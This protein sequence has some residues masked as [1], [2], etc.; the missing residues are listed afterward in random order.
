MEK[1]LIIVESPGKINKIQKYLGSD[2]IVKASCG[3]IRDLPKNDINI[4]IT[5]NFKP[6][7]KINQNK[8]KIIKELKNLSSSCKETIIATDNDREGEFIAQSLKE[9]L[10]ISNPK[11]ILFN[12]ITKDAIIQS[13]N[14]PTI[15]DINKVKSQETR[16]FLDRIIGYKLSPLLWNNVSSSAKSAGRVQSIALNIVIN[17]EKE[18]QEFLI[19]NNLSNFKIK[20]ILS[21]IDNINEKNI[22]S[23]LDYI[24]EKYEELKQ[25]IFTINKNTIFKIE[26]K[27]NKLIK[28]KPNLPFITSTLQQTSFIK[29]NMLGYK[30]MQVAQKLYEKGFITYIRTDSYTISNNIVQEIKKYIIDLYGEKYYED[31]I[32]NS[33]KYSQCAHECIRP[34]N[35]LLK[36]I[37][38]A[39][40]E[41]EQLYSLIWHR[42][43]ESQ[44]SE[45]H[46]NN[47]MLYINAF[48]DNKTILKIKEE[49]YYFTST[50]NTIIFLGY[51]ILYNYSIEDIYDFNFETQLKFYKMQGEECYMNSPSRYNESELIKILDNNNIGR[52][53]TYVSI[54]SKLQER[55]YIKLENVNGITKNKKNIFMNNSF[56]IN[57]TIEE[58][59][60]GK[61]KN[62]FVPS[63]IGIMV[64]KF[65]FNNFKNII[66]IKFTSEMEKK[67][68]DI[69][70]N[71]INYLDVLN[72]YYDILILN[73]NKFETFNNNN[74]NNINVKKNNFYNK[75][76]V[77]GTKNNM[78]IY[79]GKGKYGEY[80]KT[81]NDNVWI[82][83]SI[84]NVQKSKL[85][86]DYAHKMLIHKINK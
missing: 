84:N 3:H 51:K 58:I 73:M 42:T 30:T 79:I 28:E 11:R 25:F 17:K 45:C 19:D 37:L 22:N 62:I 57:E 86:I 77:F 35:I 21:I 68:D 75:D 20:I 72:E 64:D 27:K 47:D 48:N 80:I 67:L 63:D 71:N 40:I 46:I 70:G 18:I 76:K 74:N 5:N 4:D 10:N 7:Y 26:K 55:E 83:V 53:S 50:I 1:I 65:L 23:H 43:I 78:T 39:S 82:Y 36:K 69:A 49:Q 34:T 16:R 2:Y 54:I 8:Y 61:E 13:I 6:I 44:M 12:E 41:E 14:N 60:I 66:N 38:N 85:N 24:F 59:I 15:I 29:L 52:P 31:K 32:I 33:K 56:N 9:V 81:L